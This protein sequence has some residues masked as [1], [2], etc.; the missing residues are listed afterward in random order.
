MGTSP[1]APGLLEAAAGG[2][3]CGADEAAPMETDGCSDAGSPAAF[4]DNDAPASSLPDGGPTLDE[5]VRQ[6]I[7]EKFEQPPQP[8]APKPRAGRKRKTSLDRIGRLEGE[9]AARTGL[10]VD[11]ASQGARRSK[12]N[13]IQPL[14]YWR[15]ERV[16]YGRR[17]SA[18]FEC[19]VTRKPRDATP[20]W[21]KRARERISKP[22]EQKKG[23]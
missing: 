14:E 10:V 13:R 12:R 18:K 7:E 6:N 20:V 21:E 16:E 2:A 23:K 5:L 3:S 9:V 22:P 1:I 4:D 19:P 8:A 17:D 11:P 15:N